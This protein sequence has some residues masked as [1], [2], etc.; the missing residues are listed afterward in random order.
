MQNS[1]IYGYDTENNLVGITDAAS[2]QK[3]FAYDAL[4]RVS[5][6][7]AVREPPPSKSGN[8]WYP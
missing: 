8:H 7:G 4:E 5:H 2:H 1:T 3:A 6:V